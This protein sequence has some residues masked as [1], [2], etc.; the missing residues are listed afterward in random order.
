M[1]S[2]TPGDRSARLQTPTERALHLGLLGLSAFGL[3]VGGLGAVAGLVNPI[4]MGGP[5][6]GRLLGAGLGVVVVAGTIRLARTL[7]SV[8]RV[9]READGSWTLRSAAGWKVGTL[10]AGQPRE[11]ELRTLRFF[12]MPA[13]KP[14]RVTVVRGKLTSGGRTFRTVGA[15]PVRY[16]E[17]LAELGA[18]SS[19]VPAPW[20]RRHFTLSR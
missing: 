4:A 17:W 2:A 3:F 1:V 16:R 20:Q 12:L 6:R 7:N 14:Q 15:P 13:L 19:E 11:L 18:D 5:V 8:A 10:P 9:D